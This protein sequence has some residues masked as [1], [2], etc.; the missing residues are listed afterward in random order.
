[1]DGIFVSRTGI[2]P[3]TKSLKGSCSTAELPA[4]VLVLY[5]F[6]PKLDK[7][8]RKSLYSFKDGF[9]KGGD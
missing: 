8:G 9:G 2:E 7:I 5:N 4:R 6:E 3:V 1:M